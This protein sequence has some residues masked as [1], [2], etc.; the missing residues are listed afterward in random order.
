MLENSEV[1]RTIR[2]H[3]AKIIEVNPTYAT[4]EMTGH[5]D[6]ILSLYAQLNA[7]GV[8]LQFVRSGRI[9]ITKSRVEQL[10]TYLSE[11]EKE[12]LDNSK[13]DL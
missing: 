9:C 2:H 11:R 12:R 6:T 8:I 3:V 7:L 10:D 4:V 1:T 13:N 5:T